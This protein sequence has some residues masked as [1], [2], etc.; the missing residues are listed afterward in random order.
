MY[1]R[2][3]EIDDDTRRSGGNYHLVGGIDLFGR[4][5]VTSDHS[6]WRTRM[7]SFRTWGTLLLFSLLHRLSSR[8]AMRWCKDPLL[9][10]IAHADLILAGHDGMLSPDHFYLALA[11]RS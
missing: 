2:P 4:A 10:A 5:N 11:A 6:R 8:L 3:S 7:H 9:D 1:S